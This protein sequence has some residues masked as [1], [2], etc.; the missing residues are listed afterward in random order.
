MAHLGADQHYRRCGCT[1]L[2]IA[3]FI[4]KRIIRHGYDGTGLRA[5]LVDRHG[6]AC[7]F[8]CV[9]RPVFGRDPDI[10][11]L[12]ADHDLRNRCNRRIIR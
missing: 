9:F 6:L 11:I 2:V 5:S 1:D 7:C 12:Y 3:A 8:A 10:R 4:R